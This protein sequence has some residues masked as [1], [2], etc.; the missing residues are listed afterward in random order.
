[1]LLELCL[2][3][4]SSAFDT[5]FLLQYTK[6]FQFYNKSRSID[7]AVF[8]PLPMMNYLINQPST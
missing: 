5:T 8:L 7:N 1:M 4:G 3:F 6:H 2:I